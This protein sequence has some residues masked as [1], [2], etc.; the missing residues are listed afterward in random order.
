MAGKSGS[1][2][3]NQV[4]PLGSEGYAGIGTTTPAFHLHLTVDFI[5]RGN[6]C[7]LLQSSSG[8]PGD[9]L[10]SGGVIMLSNGAGTPAFG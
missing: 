4:L 5:F 6:S 7:I 2:N 10:V 9:V 3:E 8:L 1:N